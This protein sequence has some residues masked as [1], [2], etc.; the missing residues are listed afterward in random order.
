MPSSSVASTG[1][2]AAAAA[3]VLLP[4]VPLQTD[5]ERML[6]L[7]PTVSLTM[8]EHMDAVPTPSGQ[9]TMA[10]VASSLG[11]ASATTMATVEGKEGAGQG[12]EDYS[13]HGGSSGSRSTAAI[14]A[15]GGV[16]E[17]GVEIVDYD[18]LQRMAD[19]RARQR[20]EEKA[21]LAD[22]KMPRKISLMPRLRAQE[23]A[24]A[25]AEAI[26]RRL[27]PGLAEAPAEGHSFLD[28]AGSIVDRGGAIAEGSDDE[29]VLSVATACARLVSQLERARANAEKEEEEAAVAAVVNGNSDDNDNKT[30]DTRGKGNSA[31]AA[32]A[33]GL[34]HA[35]AAEMA[36][37]SGGAAAVRGMLGGD[38]KG[39]NYAHAVLF[40]TA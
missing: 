14:N 37:M 29:E 34:W 25:E 9:V 13:R 7:K 10:T 36:L 38:D 3:A 22:L 6:G 27:L 24:R 20:G 18:P 15:D 31:A 17:G 35:A 1:S 30:E 2:V 12:G 32:A 28:D 26:R 16:E 5:A 40:C 33:A 21:S 23:I 19:R 4:R 8:A 39:R 11:G